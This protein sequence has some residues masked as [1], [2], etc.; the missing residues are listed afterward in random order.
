M[1]AS[2]QPAKARF[3]GSVLLF[4]WICCSFNFLLA[5]I[6]QNLAGVGTAVVE[7]TQVVLVAFVVI[8]V[9]VRRPVQYSAFIYVTCCVFISSLACAIVRGFDPRVV[10][11]LVIIPIFILFGSCVPPVRRRFF[12]ILLLLVLASVLFEYL[13]P[14]SYKSV[15]NPLSYFRNTRVWIAS[16]KQSGAADSG[17]YLG[18][19]RAGGEVFSFLGSH[20]LGGVFLEPLSLGYFSVLMSIIYGQLYRLKPLAYACWII[21]C[22]AMSI[23]SD[24]RAATGIIVANILLHLI[25][26][27]YIPKGLS[28][29][30]PLIIVAVSLLIYLALPDLQAGDTVSRI[31]VTFDAIYDGGWGI[32]AGAIPIDHFGDSAIVYSIYGCGIFFIPAILLYTGFFN[33]ID[34]VD[35]RVSLQVALYISVTMMSGLALFS[36]KTAPLLGYVIGQ[37]SMRSIASSSRVR[38]VA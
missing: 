31:G 15:I 17:L 6:N 10:N 38:T 24:S 7:A 33:R 20:R 32:V 5:I 21:V 27:R 3:E 1:Q 4:I 29:I 37:L 14:E 9:I 35:R 8:F 13:M 12:N 11:D 19:E 23:L 16:S 22:L 26:S 18:S 25:P 2:E 36:I 34:R 30:L 28:T